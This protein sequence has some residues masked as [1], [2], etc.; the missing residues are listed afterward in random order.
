MRF[1]ACPTETPVIWGWSHAPFLAAVIEDNVL[2][3]AGGG[4][5]LGVEH[6]AKS[7]KSN[8]GRTYMTIALNRNVVRW[9]EP[10]LQRRASSGTRTLPPGLILGHVPSHDPDEFVV[11][12]EANRLEAPAGAKSHRKLADS[13]GA[14]QYSESREPQVQPA[15]GPG[16]PCRRPDLEFGQLRTRVVPQVTGRNAADR[17]QGT[18]NHERSACAVQCAAAAFP[19]ISESGR[20]VGAALP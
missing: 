7:I 10:F 15:H 8:K 1:A 5:I 2:E 11:R 12:A 9:T 18:G 6:S 20:A 19:M 4:S 13:R 17:R 14:I 16:R 3:D